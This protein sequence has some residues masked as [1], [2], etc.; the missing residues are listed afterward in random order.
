MPDT[1]EPRTAIQAAMVT[2]RHRPLPLIAGTSLGPPTFHVIDCPATTGPVERLIGFD[3]PREWAAVSVLA[4]GT[5][6]AGFVM[7]AAAVTRSGHRVAIVNGPGCDPLCTD[8]PTGRLID[9]CVR[10]LGLPTDPPPPTT[11]DAVRGLWLDLIM[12]R[13]VAGGPSPTWTE[14]MRLHPAWIG[15]RRP[16]TGSLVRMEERM[17]RALGWSELR[18]AVRD[19]SWP[20]ATIDPAAAA[21]MDDG[22]FARAVL[23]ELPDRSTLRADLGDLL[24]PRLLARLDRV[25]DAASKEAA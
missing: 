9:A 11:L 22:M 13:A 12:E 2:L 10:S 23:A 4:G 19:G 16:Q 3:A 7:T 25:L 21:W 24:S 8:A 5:T 6:A 1:L 14:I 17:T 18:A 20:M 15:G